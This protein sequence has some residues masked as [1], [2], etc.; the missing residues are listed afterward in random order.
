MGT[1]EEAIFAANA[2]SKRAGYDTVYS[3][4]SISGAA[5][6]GV[7]IRNVNGYRIPN[8]MEAKYLLWS[9]S[10]R[11]LTWNSNDFD[12]EW[13]KANVFGDSLSGIKNSFGAY[14]FFK[15]PGFSDPA[16]SFAYASSME[17]SRHIGT[18]FPPCLGNL[19]KS[20]CGSVSYSVNRQIADYP[21]IFVRSVR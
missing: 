19:V 14:V 20:S 6:Y 4:D 7:K 10:T 15:T 1:A 11:S 8:P 21:L 12:P 9:G 5:L 16:E 2:K 13:V 18:V 17:D 3:Y